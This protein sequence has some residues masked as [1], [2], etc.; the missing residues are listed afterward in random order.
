MVGLGTVEQAL[1]NATGDPEL[2]VLV[3]NL[4]CARKG[5][6]LVVLSTQALDPQLLRERLLAAGLPVLALPAA[7]CTVDTIPRLGSG[8]IDYGGARVLAQQL[9][10]DLD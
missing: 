10:S 5:E 8:K 6:R 1:R 9:A 2:D 7:Y 4:P 3:S